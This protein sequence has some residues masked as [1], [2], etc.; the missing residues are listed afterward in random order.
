MRLAM[1]GH[2]SPI[3]VM[4]NY[5]KKVAREGKD[6]TTEGEE[7][8]FRG[9]NNKG[10]GEVTTQSVAFATGDGRVPGGVHH[11]SA[12]LRLSYPPCSSRPAS[13]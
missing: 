10:G 1:R 2:N 4:E 13:A 3:I 11:A 5:S 7:A 12:C 8:A 6:F 9:E